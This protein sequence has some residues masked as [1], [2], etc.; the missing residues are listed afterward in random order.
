[1][2]ILIISVIKPVSWP[3]CLAWLYLDA[4]VALEAFL[5]RH[6]SLAAKLC[7]SPDT[8]FLERFMAF[9]FAIFGRVVVSCRGFARVLSHQVGLGLNGGG[10]GGQREPKEVR[11]PSRYTRPH[12]GPY[13]G[14]S[15][16]CR[17]RSKR[18][19]FPGARARVPSYM[20]T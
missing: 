5:V 16:K 2:I 14:G 9:S 6:T 10:G 4:S 15:I 20:I 18:L 12:S 1:M 7:H 19:P 17:G 13:W 11:S 3:D 8:F